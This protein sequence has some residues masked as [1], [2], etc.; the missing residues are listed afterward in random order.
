[1]LKL[2]PGPREN[3]PLPPYGDH[4]APVGREPR[5]RSTTRRA[6]RAARGR[7]ALVPAQRER[8][9]RPA[10]RERVRHHGL[11]RLDTLGLHRIHAAFL[12][13]NAASR[14]VL[15]KIGMRN[16][17]MGDYNGSPI[18]VLVLSKEHNDG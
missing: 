18:E 10:E 9:V 7:S 2:N 3:E 15:E 4:G 13:N 8:H 5:D 14:R 1:M 12:P 16:L 11:R 17:G 6:R